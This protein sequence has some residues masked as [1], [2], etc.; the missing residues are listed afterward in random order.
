MANPYPNPNPNPN[1]PYLRIGP[2][3]L[4]APHG[5]TVPCHRVLAGQGAGKLEDLTAAHVRVAAD[6]AERGGT[7]GDEGPRVARGLGGAVGD[8]LVARGYGF[9]FLPVQAVEAPEVRE[10]TPGSRA[11]A[12]AGGAD[13]AEEEEGGA[14]GV[15]VVRRRVQE[16]EGRARARDRVWDGGGGG[17]DGG[18][19]GGVACGGGRRRVCGRRSCR[20]SSG[21]GYEVCRLG[22]R[23]LGDQPPGYLYIER[24]GSWCGLLL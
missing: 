9:H 5:C 16:R 19:G 6:L 7:L 20:R 21:Q 10:E 11:R 2:A 17:S 24:G 3:R 14:G 22:G 8:A 4:D 23:G 1:L 13:A 12:H 18:G 15:A